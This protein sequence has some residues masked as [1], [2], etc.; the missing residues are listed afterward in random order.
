MAAKQKLSERPDTVRI[1]NLI[2]I[3]LTAGLGAMITEIIEG[4][5]GAS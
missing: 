5:P 1:L 3:F 2:R 4:E